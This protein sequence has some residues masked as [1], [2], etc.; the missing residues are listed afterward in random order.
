MKVYEERA[1]KVFG[2]IQKNR[3]RY[4]WVLMVDASECSGMEKKLVKSTTIHPVRV[5]RNR[6]LLHEDDFACNGGVDC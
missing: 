1:F 3:V 4:L 6:W 2:G 5:C